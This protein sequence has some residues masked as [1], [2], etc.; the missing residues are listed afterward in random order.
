MDKFIK[1][2]FFLII[3]IAVSTN[4]G[5]AK[6]D[7]TDFH[8]VPSYSIII[9]QKYYEVNKGEIVNFSIHI[10]GVGD[11]DTNKLWISIPPNIVKEKIVLKEYMYLCGWNNLSES[12]SDRLKRVLKKNYD[13]DWMEN[14]NISK[15]N[16]SKIIIISK[17]K[18]NS[19]E[20]M[21][22]E[23][24]E[25]VTM[26]LS[27]GRTPDLYKDKGKNSPIF[28]LDPYELDNFFGTSLSAN[29]FKVVKNPFYSLGE[30]QFV[31]DGG[32]EAPITFG[33]TVDDNAPEGDHEI[34]I[35]LYYKNGKQWYQSQELV[36]IHVNSWH[37]QHFNRSFHHCCGIAYLEKV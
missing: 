10:T 17:D 20:I 16:D 7:S 35:I 21:Y 24:N 23:K 8:G 9:Y 15:S 18:K 2:L 1:T 14:A 4:I 19:A 29:Y 13:V 3:I 22:D 28:Y 12:D 36:K 27:D 5:V 32:E 11:V 34:F 31:G 37:E 26:N 30:L 33:F 25:K 6:F